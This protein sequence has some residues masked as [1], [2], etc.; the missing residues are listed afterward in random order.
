LTV[1]HYD[2]GE[3]GIFAVRPFDG[4]GMADLC[5]GGGF[6]GAMPRYRAHVEM[7]E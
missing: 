4:A 2:R 3:I 1:E 7:I 5:A 6:E